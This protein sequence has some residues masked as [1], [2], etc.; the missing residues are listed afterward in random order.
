MGR[1]KMSS[2]LLTIKQRFQDGQY[3]YSNHAR[4]EMNDDGLADA[5]IASAVMRGRLVVRQTR[6]HRGTRYVVHGP[7]QDGQT[8]AVVCR[9][10]E[11]AVRVIT[12]YR[13]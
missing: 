3:V 11:T 1:R 13:V 2:A 9:L 12:V 8:V 4:V 10:R 5:D 6:G 7:A